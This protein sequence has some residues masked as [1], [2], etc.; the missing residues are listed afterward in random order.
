[1]KTCTGVAVAA[2]VG[3]DAKNEP[4]LSLTLAQPA[5]LVN[6]HAPERWKHARARTTSLAAVRPALCWPSR[7]PTSE[8]ALKRPLCMLIIAT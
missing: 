1:M 5:R 8:R 3:H 4:H 2:L 6:Q 7:R